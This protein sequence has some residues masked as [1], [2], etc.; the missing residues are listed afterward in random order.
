MAFT[1]LFTGPLPY[2]DDSAAARETHSRR[3]ERSGKVKD[4]L[5]RRVRGDLGRRLKKDAVRAGVFDNPGLLTDALL[6]EPHRDWFLEDAAGQQAALVFDGR[7]LGQSFPSVEIIRLNSKPGK[8]FGGFP[9]PGARARRPSGAAPPVPFPAGLL[10][11]RGRSRLSERQRYSQSVAM[12]VLFPTAPPSP[13][14]YNERPTYI[15]CTRQSQERRNACFCR[16][17]VRDTQGAA[18]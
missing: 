12:S 18:A 11:Q 16:S 17:Y 13:T 1:L 4:N 8:C 9:C 2:A 7:C 14:A 5:D 15:S 10:W 6:P 3:L